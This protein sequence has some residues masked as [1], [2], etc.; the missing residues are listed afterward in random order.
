[1][2]K[3]NNVLVEHQSVKMCNYRLYFSALN[4]SLILFETFLLSLLARKAYRRD[5][6][7]IE[8]PVSA[9]EAGFSALDI[10]QPPRKSE[11]SNYINDGTTSQQ[12]I[13]HGADN[14]KSAL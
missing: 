10:E 8:G 3:G 5:E 7:E 11:E 12:T 2:F 13:R 14:L 9:S 1:M 6:T 4:H